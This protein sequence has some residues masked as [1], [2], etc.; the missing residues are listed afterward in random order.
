MEGEQP[1]HPVALGHTQSDQA[2]TV[3]FRLLRGTGL[4]GLAGMQISDPRGLIRPLLTTS[5]KEV[6]E[7]AA[8]NGVAWRE[9]S[10]NND[11]RFARNRLRN[12]LIPRMTEYFNSNL[13][14]TLASTALVAQAEENYWNE[15]IEPVY[16]EITKRTWLGSI[17]NVTALGGLHLAVQRR[18]IRRTLVEIRGDL[19]GLNADHVAAVLALCRSKEGHDRVLIPGADALRSFDRLLVT[20]P[21]TL[22]SQTSLPGRGG[23]WGR[24]RFALPFRP[25]L[26]QPGER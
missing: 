1:V 26:C 5:R 9:D 24:I 8:A 4:T 22:G 20:Q 11:L 6:R 23:G 13:E 21:G 16:Q 15:A 3:L 2:E 25:S 17:L 7:W 14:G 19:R 10:S 18:V 12:E